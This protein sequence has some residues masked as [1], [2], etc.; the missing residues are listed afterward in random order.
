V[1]VVEDAPPVR[2]LLDEV[3]TAWGC[4]VELAADGAEGLIRLG[5]TRHELLLTDLQ[6]PGVSGWAIV[7]TARRRHPHMAVVLMT[8]SATD[9]DSVRARAAGV[10]LMRRPFDLNELRAIV[11]EALGAR[12]RPAPGSRA[13]R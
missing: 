1:L 13:S 10:V 5:E 2:A 11:Q 8:G 4:A 6:M 3:L 12:D 9:P 7:A